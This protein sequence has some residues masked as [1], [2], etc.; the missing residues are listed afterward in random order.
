MNGL[1]VYAAMHYREEY[2]DKASTWFVPVFIGFLEG[3]AVGVLTL[4]IFRL[5]TD[6]IQ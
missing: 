1:L 2:Q 6:A 5:A 4:S 3:L